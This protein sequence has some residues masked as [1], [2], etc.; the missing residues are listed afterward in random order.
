MIKIGP[1]IFMF[2]SL[3]CLRQRFSVMISPVSTES[4]VVSEFISTRLKD[5]E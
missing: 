5:I 2:T 3:F 1:N 4:F